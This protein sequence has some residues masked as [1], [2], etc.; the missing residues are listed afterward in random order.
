[1]WFM[2]NLFE[3][4][5]SQCVK[6]IYGISVWDPWEYTIFHFLNPYCGGKAHKYNAFHMWSHVKNMG[7]HEHVPKSHQEHAC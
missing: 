1:M 4:F 2:W 5:Q 7:S 3:C 6:H